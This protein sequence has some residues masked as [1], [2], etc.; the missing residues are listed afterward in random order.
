MTTEK[1]APIEIVPWVY[2]NDPKAKE[3]LIEMAKKATSIMDFSGKIRDTYKLSISDAL[4]V[5]KK[6]FN[7]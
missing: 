7:K 5:A 4:I 3:D 6:F 2:F 1:K